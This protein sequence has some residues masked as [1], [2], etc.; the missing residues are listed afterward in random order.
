M[1]LAGSPLTRTG[2][3]TR[4]PVVT[5]IILCMGAAVT[6]AA[7]QDEIEIANTAWRV[8]VW[9]QTLRIVAAG[10][11]G[12]SIE[13]SAGQGEL[14]QVSGLTRTVD[15]ASWHLRDE[16]IAIAVR[17]DANDLH[18]QI[19]SNDQGAFTWPVVRLRKQ[20]KALI[21]PHAEGAYIPL[22]N[23]RWRDYLVERGE[24]DTLASLSMPFWGLDC[25]DF[26]LTYVATCPYNNIIRFIREGSRLRTEFT[27]EFTQFQEP[28]EYGFVISLSESR[29]PIEPARRFRRWLAEHDRFVPMQDKMRQI[30]KVERLLGAAHVY[31]WGDGV[32][33]TMLEQ[34]QEAGLDRLRLCTDGWEEV[35]K[36]PEVARRADELGYLFGTYDGFDSIHDP[37][38]Q[39]TDGTWPTA[40]FN[41]PLYE[42]GP[43]LQKDGT[44]RTGFQGVGAMLSPRAARP[45]VEQRVRRNMANVPY[46]YYFVDCDATGD[47]QDDYSPLHPAGQADDAA[48]RADRLR[49]I[50][51]TFKVPVGSEGG[52]FLF[53]GVIHVSEGVFGALFGWGDPDLSDKNSRYFLGAY[54][55]PDG[56]Q[57]FTRQVP[58]KERYKLLCYDPRYRLPLYETVFHD[59]VVATS[60]WRNASLK[61]ENI[62]ETVALTEMLY[63]VPPM[64]HMNLN[65]FGKHGTAMK[66]HYEFFSPLHRELGFARMTDFDWLSSDRLMQRTTFDPGVEL[67][68]N[69]STQTRQYKGVT[70]PGRSLLARWSQNG[71]SKLYTPAARG[72]ADTN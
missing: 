22:D 17:L 41:R 8:A 19:R 51:E 67:I 46:S 68:A 18:V 28:R 27:H 20:V 53:A 64:Y 38:L 47:V 42:N 49:W 11:S 12:R 59:S 62:L 30:P 31:L 25:G 63:M 1:T 61:F 58:I 29:S 15:S 44:P 45:Y 48:A 72:R 33:L 24:W 3:R 35:E 65:E 14:G 39:G 56:P 6:A 5:A 23:A 69:Y 13:L 37:T 7:S 21:W 4:R 32:S 66:R 34:F 10:T 26:T 55:P 9:P 70:I 2:D 50:A 36:R 60:H 43:I 54:Y 57:I 40:Q 16:R 52:C 71:E